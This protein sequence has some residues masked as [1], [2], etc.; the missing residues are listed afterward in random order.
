[1]TKIENLKA[2]IDIK[3][4]RVISLLEQRS[5]LQRHLTAA[6]EL[7]D[8]IG[9]INGSFAD[10]ISALL[11]TRPLINRNKFMNPFARTD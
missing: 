2:K 1:M 6:K 4:T 11:F 3:V 10:P 9:T 5:I 7:M 8:S